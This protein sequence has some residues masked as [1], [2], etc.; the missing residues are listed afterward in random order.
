MT[1]R[2]R[3]LALL[4]GLPLL[5]LTLLAGILLHMESEHHRQALQER[6]LTAVDLLGPELSAALAEGD[7]AALETLAG[8]LLELEEVRAV[9]IRGAE[10]ATRLEL[11]RLR[12]ASLPAEATDTRLDTD[13]RLW[14]LQAPL[15]AHP[16]AAAWLEVDI[17]AIS[18]V[19]DHYRR[20]ASA[21][22]GLLVTG[23]LLWLLAFTTGRHLT[24]PVQAAD[25]A[26]ARLARDDR[27]PPLSV[28]GPPELAGLVERV[29]AL[30]EHLDRA[31]DEARLQIEQTTAE[32][33]ESM[34]TIEVQNIELDMAHRRALEANRIKSEFLA[35]M[36]HEI[37]TPLNGIIGFC[38]LLGRSRLE[39]RQREWLDHVHRACDNLLMLVN[40]VLDFSKIEAG[41]LELEHVALDMVALVDDV[42]ALQAP[43]AH[44]K[45]LQL[46]GL[47]YD[48]VPATLTGDPLRIRQVLTNLV[49]NAI[50]FTE[51][52]EVIVRVMVEQAEPGRVT[53]RISV[54]DT[55]I[56]LS[57]E[58]CQRL[59]QAFRQA[60]PSH[61]REFGGTGLGLTICRQLVEQ[62][63]GEIGVESEPGVGSTFAFT[64]PL[65]GDEACE[66]PPEL[67]LAGQTVLLDEPHPATWRALRHL[68]GRWGARVI[69]GRQAPPDECSPALLVAG[70]PDQ[71]LDA[72]GVATWQGRLDALACPALLLVNTSP[73]DL[74]MLTLSHGGEILSK[75]FSRAALV[76][77]VQRQLGGEL[78]SGLP[79]VTEE[80]GTTT[81]RLL[82]VD[83]TESNRLLLREL[84][85]RP[86]L[87][88]DLAASGEEALAMAQERCYDLVL[89][90]IRM[91]GMDGVETTRA[92][93]RLRGA[94]SHLPIVAVTA[95]VL[96][97]ERRRLLAGG[98]DDVLIKPLDGHALAELLQRHLDLPALPAAE[99]AGTPVEP[100]GDDGELAVVDLAL[101]TRLAGGR[102]TLARELLARLA[103]SLPESEAAIRDALEREDDEALLDAIHAL[104]G[105]CRYCGAPRLALLAETLETRLR[106]RGREGVTP[107]LDDLF[108]A[109]AG[110]RD[111][112]AT[113]PSSTT[114][115]TASS[116]SSVND[117]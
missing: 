93:R 92:M 84:I 94:W 76:E 72:A 31:R 18:L 71:A 19:L 35:N 104:N 33:Q 63:G 78:P 20:L 34:E 88:V 97:E 83:D 16:A 14:R 37:R 45:D 117:R 3:L 102:E 38:R 51:R 4:L 95:H 8:R 17:D 85:Q 6:L 81:R 99:T 67:L 87:V 112:Q 53:L 41:R 44:Q 113:Q 42:L 56:G 107:L 90:D 96:E 66:R 50:K 40:D 13:G 55:G 61:S 98:L 46:L 43:H 74:P 11:G 21:G 116:S 106:S 12:E 86:G 73:L 2:N 27:P 115:A 10:G 1:L 105:A 62:M 25:R 89:M 65:E 23:L 70:I 47:V 75:P 28:S 79:A 108:A 15:A 59:F 22:V 36:S 111:W 77:A 48:D 110:L 58:S 24:T 29:N 64:L 54:S 91:P 9:G 5:L 114:K 32:L 30:S 7:R 82:A 68:L 49:N 103:A 69:D 60:N 39:P 109:M 57:P 100:S 26:L 101:G 52:G 80:A